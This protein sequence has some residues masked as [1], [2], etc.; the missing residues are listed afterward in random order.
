MGHVDFYPNGGY[1]QPKCPKT[2]GK[3]INLFLQLSQMN[4][5]GNINFDFNS[6]NY[7]N[8]FY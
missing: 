7:L 5:E 2:P 1:N 3:I 4:V 8:R 6:I